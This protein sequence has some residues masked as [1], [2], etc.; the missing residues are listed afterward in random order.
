VNDVLPVPA[1]TS[2]GVHR[3]AV[4]T[5][6]SAYLLIVAGGLV[7]GTRS[8]DSCRDWPLCTAAASPAL[9]GG[10]A[11]ENGHRVAA[12]L[13]GALTLA[14]AVAL[15]R[16]R[17][18]VPAL[19]RLGW[20]AVG[21]VAA[22]GALGGLGVVFRLPDGVAA[23]H[24]G[25]SL[26]FFLTL[27]YLAAQTAAGAEARPEVAPAAR[28]MAL[29]AALAVLF[30]ALLGALVRAS[31]AALACP[32][33]PFCRGVL[34]PD[35]HVTAQL[36]VLHRLGA[37]ATALLV[38]ASAA[39]AVPA[40]TGRPWLRTLALATPV[41]AA[42]QISLGVRSVQTFLDLAVVQAHL[43]V[44]AALLAAS[45]GVYVLS[46]P[47]RGQTSAP[48]IGA[49]ARALV[50]LC[51]PRITTLV[52]IT[53]A[54]GLWLAP[55]AVPA[56]RRTAA[57]LGTVLIVAAAN[58]LNMYLERDVDG[59]MA[60]TRRRPLPEGRLSPELALGFGAAL[61]FVAVPLLLVGA[62]PLTAALGVLALA[63]YVFAYTP[64][65]RVSSAALLVGAVPGAM[66]PLMGWTTATSQLAPAGLAL[67]AILFVWQVPH[68]LA[69]AVYRADDYARA[70]FQVLPRTRGLPATRWHILIS[71]AV[72]VAVSL[73]PVR[74]HVA[75]PL[76]LGCA[77]VAGAWFLA[78]AA[79]GF[80]APSPRAWA[81]RVFIVS[82]GYLVALFLALA[83][84]H[85]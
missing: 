62:N 64:L 80:R 48:G 28:R 14:L 61:A 13:V 17:Q 25:V 18:G 46:A 37:V 3:F 51:K 10:V 72:L 53:F 74:H 5:A 27:F 20:L 15:S 19:P 34:W 35:A 56:W 52:V 73:L 85:R 23:V 11:L 68:F 45:W 29:V 7:H 40:T 16:A 9:S 71:T 76:Y 58:A 78:A 65:K 63:V 2:R 4:I 69:I 50:E 24:T 22:Q 21:L 49:R 42:A 26:I 54:G 44:G 1:V 43:A 39:R 6:L 33:L 79:A 75:G 30:Q 84:G 70:G 67:F 31:G 38:F 41:L 59:R 60:R 77:L 55:G 57:L 8:T 12:A 82:L 32:E 81:R 36:Q 66:P 47:S 83:I